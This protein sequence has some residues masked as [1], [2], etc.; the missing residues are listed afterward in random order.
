[1]TNIMTN[2]QSFEY[3]PNQDVTSEM[4]FQRDDVSEDAAIRAGDI[5][6]LST[7]AREMTPPC[8]NRNKQS[9]NLQGS[10]VLE[11]YPGSGNQTAL[12]W[13]VYAIK[14]CRSCA[15]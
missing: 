13:R 5:T 7:G 11:F 4:F 8:T 6:R 14:A 2:P 1:M 3:F 10:Q 9:P 15:P 12:K